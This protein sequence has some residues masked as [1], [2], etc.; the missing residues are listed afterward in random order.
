MEKYFVITLYRHYLQKPMEYLYLW[1]PYTFGNL[2]LVETLHFWKPY[3]FG[4]LTLLE[5]LHS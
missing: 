5:N 4:N 1:R 2:T 3:T